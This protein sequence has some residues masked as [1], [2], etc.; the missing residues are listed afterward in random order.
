MCRKRRQYSKSC[1]R[2]AR[3]QLSN[4]IGAFETSS[5]V[6]AYVW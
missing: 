5:D 2:D 6:L 3:L 4:K 1:T